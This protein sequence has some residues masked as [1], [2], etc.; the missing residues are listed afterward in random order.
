MPKLLDKAVEWAKQNKKNRFT[1]ADTEAFLIDTETSL[2]REN[3][4]LLYSKINT[5]LKKIRF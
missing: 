4:D 5:Q 3:Y 2:S 1:K